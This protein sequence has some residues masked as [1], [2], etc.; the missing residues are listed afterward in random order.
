MGY[1]ALDMY[2]AVACA[3]LL[4][5]G[6]GNADPPAGMGRTPLPNAGTA[7]PPLAGITT[8]G[9]GGF[10]AGSGAAGTVAGTGFAGT[11]AG[12]AAAAGTGAGTSAGS[13]GMPPM[14]AGTMEKPPIVLCDPETDAGVVAEDDAGT[15][16]ASGEPGDCVV[17]GEVRL[18]YRAGDTNP[19]DNQIKPQFNILNDSSD[20]IPLTELTIRYWFNQAG[21]TPL[22]FFCDYAQIGQTLVMGS[23]EAVERDGA[24]RVLEITFSGGSVGAGQQTGEIQARFS[25]ED[26][27]DMDEQDDYSFDPTKTAFEDW[28][29]VTLYRR[30]TLIWGQEP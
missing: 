15:D 18:Q 3:M 24:D 2:C 19:L 21:G 22:A 26:W 25:H 9:T 28:H 27:A 16:S 11:A 13:G 10:G 8:A 7:A 20:A 5:V 1:R 6:C 23:F 12:T 4:S 17:A 30:G 29:K 14:D